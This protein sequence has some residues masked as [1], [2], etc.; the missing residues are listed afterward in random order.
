MKPEGHGAQGTGT[1]SPQAA[2]LVALFAFLA[3]TLQGCDFAT[4]KVPFWRQK[5]EYFEAAS[6][7]D[8]DTG[9]MKYNSCMNPRV[10][11]LDVCNRKGSCVPFDPDDITN[12]IFFCKCQPEY[13][14]V[15]CQITRKSQGTAWV[16]SLLFGWIGFDSLYLDNLAGFI[17]QLIAFCIGFPLM[18]AH[19]SSKIP[20]MLLFTLP[21]M[22]DAIKIGT[23][24]AEAKIYRTSADLPRWVFV[25][26]S[27]SYVGLL[28]L[29]VGVYSLRHKI[30]R[31]RLN[32]EQ[33]QNYSSAK[34]LA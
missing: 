5:P 28:C 9:A 20:G 33:A 4:H 15:E 25:L 22:Y 1:V 8:P 26:F 10:S 31:K 6:Y 11:L 2:G 27:I 13:G 16:L 21:W 7:K 12:P 32:W 3:T 29:V 19:H 34:I 30:Q 18:V 14:G 23:A 24:P 17:F